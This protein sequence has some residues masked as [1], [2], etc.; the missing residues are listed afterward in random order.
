MADRGLVQ[1]TS[2]VFWK[3]LP[4]LYAICQIYIWHKS[5]GNGKR[6]VCQVSLKAVL[7]IFKLKNKHLYLLVS[8]SRLQTWKCNP[9]ISTAPFCRP[10]RRH[11]S[12]RA[13]LTCLFTF[14]CVANSVAGEPLV[15]LTHL[16]QVQLTSLSVRTHS[17][18]FLQSFD[19]FCRRLRRVWAY[20]C[21]CVS[22]G[23]GGSA[24][25]P[26]DK[27]VQQAQCYQAG[28]TYR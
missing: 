14:L 8:T 11:L 3:V 24:G 16:I 1:S 25:C 4:F 17:G 15:S 9:L 23:G 22:G 28:H 18:R 12:V 13:L 26:G 7:P 21:I 5:T 19:V 6:S 10:Y 20:V 27:A 2:K